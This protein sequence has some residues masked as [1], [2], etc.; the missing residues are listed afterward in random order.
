MKYQIKRGA[1]IL[2]EV[3]PEGNITTK[4]MGEELVSM[5]FTLSQNVV[6]KTNDS[7]VVYGNTYYLLNEPIIDKKSSKEYIY[8]LQFVGIK[9]EL[10]KVQMF[11]PDQNNELTVS[12]FSITGT[13]SQMIDLVVQNANRVQNGWSVGIVGNNVGKQVDFN[14]HNCLT[15]I[16]KIAEE[17]EIEYWIDGDKTIHLAERK[18]ASGYSFEYGKGQ[19]LQSINRTPFDNSN[20]VTRLYAKGS[21]TNIPADYRNYSKH[22]KMP[23]SYLE[24]NIDKYGIIEHIESF[25]D[26][27]PERI[28]TVTA[29]NANNPLQFTDADIDFDLN[30]QDANGSVILINNVPAKVTFNTGQLAGYTFEVKQHGYNTATKTF[31]LLPNKDEKDLQVPSDLLRPAVGDTYVITDIVMPQSYINDAETRLQNAAQ[32]YLDENSEQRHK[33]TVVSDPFYLKE[34]NAN[35]VLGKTINFK[36]ADF[37]LDA[38]LRV[39]ALTK[40]LQNPYDVSFDIAEKAILSAVVREYIEAEK[41]NVA[42]KNADKY[43]AD[44]ARRNYAFAKEFQDNVFDNE[45][46]FD[47]E[48]IKP[49]SI[50][51]KMLS[52]GSR[53]QQFNLIDV[54]FTISEDNTSVSNTAGKLIHLTV[55]DTVREWDLPENTVLNI[56]GTFH[57]IYI[58]A[59]RL[60]TNAAIVIS[61]EQ[62]KVESDQNWYHFEVGYLSSVIDN[63]RRIKTTYGF[64]QISP[65]EI[66]TGRVSSP[67]GENYIEFLQDKINIHANVTFGED[68]ELV[69]GENFILQ[70]LTDKDFYKMSAAK[71]D[72][73]FSKELHYTF[74]ADAKANSNVLG[75]FVA[76]AKNNSTGNFEVIAQKDI[77]LVAGDESRIKVTVKVKL[78]DYGKII[79]KAVDVNG[80]VDIELRNPKFELG[81]LASDYNKSNDDFT[82]SINEQI[83]RV[84]QVEERTNFIE[85]TTIAGNTVATGVL[86]VGDKDG[87][88]AGITGVTDEAEKSVRFFAGS[89]FKNRKKA[90]FR[91][92]DN[93]DVVA[94]NA[95]VKG[96]VEATSGSFKGHIEAET[97][98]FKGH[99]EAA[100]GKIGGFTIVGDKITGQ[101]ILAD[102]TPYATPIYIEIHPFDGVKTIYELSNGEKRISKLQAG[103]VV[104]EYYNS[105]GVLTSTSTINGGGI[106]VYEDSNNNTAIFAG[107]ISVTKNGVTRNL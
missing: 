82:N 40:S 88:N 14:G 57:Y 76:V 31:E 44:M 28:G 37:S 18:S 91:V 64:T 21:E 35:I 46:Y 11:F 75:V 72:R 29:V 22:L 67:N 4:I 80:V 27:K 90:P 17:F 97:G 89:T 52:V 1:T 79:Y 102:G 78:A 62:I 60:G 50:E 106:T 107:T 68:S 47:T 39:V 71:R 55:G 10:S 100:S 51:T 86:M 34:I 25:E 73:Y 61:T 33:Y 83:A 8:Q 45:G 93:G 7:V 96:H 84:I 59:E 26:I 54:A 20:I 58:K 43:N 53:M 66:S 74:S 63:V 24:K 99:I 9:Y 95:I 98:E 103:V 16:A 41:K 81:R 87:A 12:E 49:L 65:S 2:A 3:R 56:P 85:K 92:L 77:A 13:A 70:S 30:E 5:S 48:K 104:V 23:V 94:E 69:G 32:T 19:G 101:I 15:A 36:D 105:S 38:N 42:I 6:F